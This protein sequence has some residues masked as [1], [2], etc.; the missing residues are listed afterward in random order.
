M[1]CGASV[2]GAFSEKED[3]INSVEDANG[4]AEDVCSRCG[5]VM[6]E[7]SVACSFCGTPRR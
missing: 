1:K 3:A 4:S 2:N 5:N 6:L 7:G